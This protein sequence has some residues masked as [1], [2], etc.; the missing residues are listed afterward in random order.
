MSK[1][2]QSVQ[3]NFLYSQITSKYFLIN[4]KLS[5]SY[6]EV[7]LGGLVGGWVVWWD[8]GLVGGML[9]GLVGCWVGW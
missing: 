6:F 2:A 3:Y 7:Y 1:C 8:V 5:K 4:Y 9:G